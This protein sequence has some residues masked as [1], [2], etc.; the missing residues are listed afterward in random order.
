MV[1]LQLFDKSGGTVSSSSRSVSVGENSYQPS[2]ST[3]FPSC[4]KK[5]PKPPDFV[6]MLNQ[7]C[8]LVKK[9]TEFK[10][11]CLSCQKNRPHQNCSTVCDKAYKQIHAY[12]ILFDLWLSMEFYKFLNITHTWSALLLFHH[13]HTLLK[14]TCIYKVHDL[15]LMGIDD[16][17]T[18]F[19]VLMFFQETSTCSCSHIIEWFVLIFS[20]LCAI[21]SHNRKMQ[22]M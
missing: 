22:R 15:L 14:S 3:A 2:I 17:S 13:I 5:P 19:N 10:T 21:L 1:K 20:M 6:I 12:V 16:N 9:K 8:F 7:G 18:C 4:A 11:V